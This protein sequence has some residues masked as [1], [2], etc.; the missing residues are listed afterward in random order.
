MKRVWLLAVLFLTA[1]GSIQSGNVGVRTMYG[2]VEKEAVSGFYSAF[3]S[4][5]DEYSAKEN[6]IDLKGLT[7]K[8]RDNLSLRDMDVSVYY[9][10]AP[11]A[12]RDLSVKYAGQSV[13]EDHIWYPAYGLVSNV[14]RNAVYE[15]VAKA[16]SLTIH[17]QREAMAAAIKADVQ[18]AMDTN[19]PG[20]F[21]ITRVLIR[22][23]VTDPTIEASIQQAVAFQK[24]LES[25]KVQVQIAEQDALV[26]VAEAKGIA[27][28]QGIINSTLTREYLQHESNEV[29]KRFADKGGVTTVILPA[30]TSVTPLL[31]M[32]KAP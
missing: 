10:A 4:H 31:N 12:I 28:A 26:R 29:M 7:P 30:N 21:T 19:D 22:A 15:E 1:C 6:E 24:N 3:L 20:V 11:G 13:K 14:S 25:K 9:K 2:T 8:A 16:D 17:L 5:V 18:K 23:V 27:S 32:G